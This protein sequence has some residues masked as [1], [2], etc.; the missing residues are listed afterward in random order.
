MRLFYKLTINLVISV[1]F[2]TL[3]VGV[4]FADERCG[5]GRVYDRGVIG[6]I[7]ETCPPTTGRNY[8]GVCQCYNSDWGGPVRVD[9]RDNTGLLTHCVAE[10]QTCDGSSVAP[11][12]PDPKNNCAEHAAKLQALEGKQEA[13]ESLSRVLAANANAAVQPSRI[14]DR[15]LPHGQIPFHALR[16]RALA[17]AGILGPINDNLKD[18]AQRIQDAKNNIEKNECVGG[19]IILD[20]AAAD[21]EDDFNKVNDAVCAFEARS[22]II[23]ESNLR[24]TVTVDWGKFTEGNKCDCARFSYQIIYERQSTRF[25]W[26]LAPDR[27]VIKMIS[28]CEAKEF[29]GEAIET[30]SPLTNIGVGLWTGRTGI[31]GFGSQYRVYGEMVPINK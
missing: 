22:N 28:G 9:C 25:G 2:I 1:Y 5:P 26:T 16:A 11:N 10:G 20:N 29:D 13:I 7:Q 30:G 6:C 3:G 21:V 27:K 24:A 18:R 15:M 23:K 17:F 19:G 31:A 8:S 4:V 12:P 14:Y